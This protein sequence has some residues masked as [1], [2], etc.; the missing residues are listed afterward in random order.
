M[1]KPTSSH[2]LLLVDDD[3][4][5]IEIVNSILGEKY[6]IRVATNGVKAL[7]LVNKEPTP[8]LILLDVIMPHMD[9]YEV[10]R[11]L[12]ENPKTRDIPV[13]FLTG[14]TDVGD[15]TRGFE[16]GAVDYIHK[17][18]SPPVVTARVRTHLM[19][20]DAHKTVA[21]Q[22][23]TMNNELEM[24][25]QVQL[26]ILPKEIPH[27][28]GL[29]I[30]AR[31]LPMTSVAGDFY[32]FLVVDDKHLGILIADVTGH[33]LPSALIASML[34]NALAWQC[35]Y[36]ADPG[37]VLAGLNRAVTGK[38]ER[39]FVTA[40][41]LF[42]DMENSI[43]KYAG[44]AHPPL[45]LWQAKLGRATELSENGLMLG[46]FADATYASISF[47]LEQGDRIV[48]FTDGLIE[49]ENSSA[50]DFGVERVKQI[51]ESKH[52]LRPARFVDALLY[53]LSGWSEKA[54]GSSQS[55]DITLLVIDC[56]ASA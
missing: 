37:Q 54:I 53:G 55:D 56:E 29:E 20:R 41:Y 22:L 32:D 4:E 36:A 43:L 28:S 27:L 39:H 25:R 3:A 38:F 16:V 51:L 42:V 45:L 52:N 49:V 10:C 31:Y 8:G 24:A 34:Q 7:E 48:L 5:N 40:A 13:I 30:A 15:E 11:H 47:P 46:P 50:E 17:P 1:N 18:F 44:A 6:Q 35:P 14:K 9:G 26:S 23:A 2:V 33:G 19:L 21:G 12:K